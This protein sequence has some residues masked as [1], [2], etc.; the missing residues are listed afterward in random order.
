M[1]L[2]YAR[3][4]T[5]GHEGLELVAR[6]HE[7]DPDL[8]VVVMIGWSTVPLAVAT[9]REG[10]CD[11]VEK[12]WDNRRLLVRAI[13]RMD[14]YDLGVAWSVAEHLGGDAYRLI[15]H[16]I[17]LQGAPPAQAAAALLALA[18]DFAGG[19]LDDDATVVVVDV[20]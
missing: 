13:P 3:D 2:N 11:F 10:A 17:G 4:T 6:V 8:P 9:M 18:R 14:G 15:A 12:P 20:A 7:L 1:D 19:S 5:S 16:L